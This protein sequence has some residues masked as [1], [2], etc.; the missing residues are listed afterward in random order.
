MDNVKMDETIRGYLEGLMGWM[1]ILRT[2]ICSSVLNG[3]RQFSHN[4]TRNITESN[5]RVSITETLS[6]PQKGQSIKS[7]L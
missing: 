1:V 5:L 2:K 3:L 7:P 4:L 6:D